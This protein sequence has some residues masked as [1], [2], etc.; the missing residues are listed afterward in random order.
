[1]NWIMVSTEYFSPDLGLWYHEV[2]EHTHQLN[3]CLSSKTFTTE[4]KTVMRELD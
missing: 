1:M 2:Y 3:I 4:V